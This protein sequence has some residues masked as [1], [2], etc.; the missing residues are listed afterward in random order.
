MP[1]YT[2]LQHLLNVLVQIVNK[3][4][5]TKRNKAFVLCSFETFSLLGCSTVYS[6]ES[7]LTFRKLHVPL[8]GWHIFCGLHEAI[9]QI[10]MIADVTT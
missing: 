6:A 10:F 3:A 4:D 7:Q 2:T 5:S 9:S 1:L 8:K